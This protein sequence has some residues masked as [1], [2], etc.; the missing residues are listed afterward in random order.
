VR[1]GPEVGIVAVLVFAVVLFFFFMSFAGVFG[2][3]PGMG[4]A[5]VVCIPILFV[6]L[7]SVLGFYRS[8]SRRRTIPPPPPIQQPMV[9][10]GQQGP[11]T[12]DCPN[13]GGPPSNV[14]RFGIAVCSYC[15]TRFLVR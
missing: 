11:V 7:I 4:P 9:P 15:G 3:I 2:G 10:A 13:C 6:I 14:D 8:T 1:G 5:G 12:L